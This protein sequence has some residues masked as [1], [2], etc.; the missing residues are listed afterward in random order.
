VV[1]TGPAVATVI[2]GLDI[3]ANNNGVAE[4]R[5]QP[6]AQLSVNEFTNIGGQGRLNVNG[7][8]FF[9]NY[10]IYNYGGFVDLNGGQ[11]SGGDINNYGTVTANGTIGSHVENNGTFQA[12]NATSRFT[13]SVNSYQE[14]QIINTQIQFDQQFN[15]IENDGNNQFGRIDVRNSIIQFTIGLDNTG[16]FNVSFG[17]TDIFGPVT[18]DTGGQVI[19]SGNSNVTFYDRLIHNGSTFRISPGSTAIFFGLVSGAGDFTG[20]GT[21]IFEGG[22]SP[23]NSPAAVSLDGPVTFDTSNSLNIEIGGPNPGTGFDQVNVAGNLNLGGTLNV[24]LYNGYLPAVGA[25]FQIVNFTSS[26]GAFFALPSSNL[27]GA[28]RTNWTTNQTPTGIS[29]TFQSAFYDLQNGTYSQNLNVNGIPL[30]KSTTSTATLTGLYSA[31]GPVTINA[32]K[33]VF[34]STS[35]ARQT[36]AVLLNMQSLSLASTT[37][38]DI[39]NHDLIIGNASVASVATQIL[40]GMGSGNVTPAITSSAAKGTGTTFIIPVNADSFLGNGSAG[41]AI[42][43]VF[44]G[45]TIT[46]PSSVIVKYTYFG[47]LN[48]DGLVNAADFNIFKSHL[49]QTSPGA[50]DISTSWLMGDVNLD[51]IINGLDYATMIGNF[52]APALTPLGGFGPLGTLVPEPTSLSLLSLSTLLLLRRS[53]RS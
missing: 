20:G 21:K 11:I 23:G 18:N 48:L 38:L 29:V 9:G 30:I 41:S 53:K 13:N 28:L 52:S 27:N 36:P 46:Q 2:R 1:V 14:F 44:D 7:G 32:G 24:T 47:D 40:N 26:T 12:I 37:V 22:Y 50:S 15:N 6:G 17:T 43:K 8:T 3:N 39:T 49:G 42:G 25:T 51:G 5:L 10:G 4:L 33:L 19:I 16:Q 45:T 34:A 31:N 35:A